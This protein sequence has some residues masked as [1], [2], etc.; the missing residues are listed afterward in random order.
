MAKISVPPEP[1]VD[2]PLRADARRNRQKVMAAAREAF[3]EHGS[4]AQMDDVARRAEVGVGTVYRHFPTKEALFQA[5][6]EDTFA[7]IATRSRA[8]LDRD[9][10]WQALTDMLWD[11]G[12]ELAGD[13][14]LVEAMEADMPEAPCPGQTEM[15]EI[16][17]ELMRRAQAAGAMRPDA[18]IDDI[19]MLMCGIGAAAGRKQHACAASWQRHLAI[20][21]DGLRARPDCT[22]LPE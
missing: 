7:R 16:G 8:L 3:R 15:G 1:P 4:E 22:P 13:R 2:K 21:L 19:P 14:A 6:R 10:A 11:A 18:M 12:H 17:G 5:L 9:D 20:V